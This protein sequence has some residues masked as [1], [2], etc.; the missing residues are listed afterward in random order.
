M[1]LTFIE[2][3]E[4]VIEFL[5]S[6]SIGLVEYALTDDEWTAVEDLVYVLKV[7]I[8][9]SLNIHSTYH[10]WQTFKDATEFFSANSPNISAVI[11]AMD[12]LDKKFATGVL[13]D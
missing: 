6:S 11:P 10:A 5:D 3:K 12:K 1:L 2:M 13:D 7:S 8:S 9:I 4:L